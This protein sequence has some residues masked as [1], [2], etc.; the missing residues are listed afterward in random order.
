[1]RIQIQH[2]TVLVSK[3]DGRCPPARGLLTCAQ[4]CNAS[5]QKHRRC[6]PLSVH[7]LVHLVVVEHGREG[8]WAER[9]A[10]H[11]RIT[12]SLRVRAVCRQRTRRSYFPA[13]SSDGVAGASGADWP[14]PV[15]MATAAHRVN[16][17]AHDNATFNE[18]FNE[19]RESDKGWEA[20]YR[21]QQTRACRR[22][23]RRPHRGPGTQRRSV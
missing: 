1:M 13:S 21:C 8:R 14:T 15:W 11:S 10:A 16:E 5:T 9:G 3:A 18:I 6:M 2:A 17:D 20:A 7:S 12:H 22:S 19:E 4:Q 23:V